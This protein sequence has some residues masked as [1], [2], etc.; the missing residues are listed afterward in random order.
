MLRG[1]SAES[2]LLL[3]QARD[4][5]ASVSLRAAPWLQPSASAKSALSPVQL[6]AKCRPWTT[7]ST[8]T[9]SLCGCS[10]WICQEAGMR[11]NACTSL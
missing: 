7:L 4:F 10:T 2:K 6:A 5:I 11:A 3:V 8:Q 9:R 1:A